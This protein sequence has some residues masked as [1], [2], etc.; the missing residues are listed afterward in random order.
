MQ[1]SVT[2]VVEL[3]SE[4]DVSQ[5]EAAIQEAGRQAMRAALKQAVRSYEEAHPAC[6][7]CGGMQSQPEGTV[8]RRVLTRFGR[9]VLQLRRQRCGACWR[10]FR[11]AQRCVQALR[12]GNV[13]PEL[14]AACALAGASWPYA[15]AARVLHDLC[16]AQVSVEEVRRWTM[17]EGTQEAQAQQAEAE[18][19]LAPTAEQVR[20][21][22]DAEA[23]RQRLG[24]E[25]SAVAAPTRLTVGLDGGWLPCREQRGGMEGKVGVVA[26]GVETVGKHGRQRL[27]PR[28]YVAHL[29][30]QRAGG[31]ANLY[32]SGRAGW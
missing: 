8:A 26:T 7:H 4:A 5:M 20:S 10:R 9:V 24:E 18:A 29:C 27:T 15:T 28:R 17:R 1:C 2:I 6:S 32:G 14:G 22:R 12:G 30:Q 19:L 21:N 3:A 25:R 23:R 13:T 11:P 16:G 31:R